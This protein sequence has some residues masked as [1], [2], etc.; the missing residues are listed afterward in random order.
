MLINGRPQ[1]SLLWPMPAIGQAVL[2]LAND[3]RLLSN[4]LSLAP[5]RS[6][7]YSMSF[8]VRIAA[9]SN[10]SSTCPYD[11]YSYIIGAPWCLKSLAIWLFIQQLVQLCFTAFGWYPLVTSR[12]SSQKVGNV[13]CTS[14]SWCEYDLWI[15]FRIS[16]NCKFSQYIRYS[17]VKKEYKIYAIDDSQVLL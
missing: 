13:D 5:V 8:V 15:Q 9:S 2:V 17:H 6:C 4:S 11:Y 16:M 7:I 10:T 12:I 1:G 14:I 3:W